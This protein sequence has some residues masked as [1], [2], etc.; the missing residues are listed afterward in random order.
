MVF[1]P[2][3]QLRH[4]RKNHR[5]QFHCWA[6]GR[7][8][9]IGSGITVRR[10]VVGLY[11]NRFPSGRRCRRRSLTPCQRHQDETAQAIRDSDLGPA[12]FVVD[13]SDLGSEGSRVRYVRDTPSGEAIAPLRLQTTPRDGLLA[14]IGDG[15]LGLGEA[16]CPEEWLRSPGDYLILGSR[17]PFVPVART[18][19]V[20]LR[21][22][23]GQPGVEQAWHDLLLK[24]QGR[25]S[26]PARWLRSSPRG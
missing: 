17:A 22:T 20:A 15:G 8:T 16:R 12:C 11:G 13:I 5:I 24:T 7:K 1:P 18:P 10:L 19:S 23:T 9:S 25:L 4:A 21:S 14:A 3:V 26:I 6:H 2:S